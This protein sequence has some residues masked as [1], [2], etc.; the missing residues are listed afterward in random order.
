V[1][2]LAG[3]S[4]LIVLTRQGTCDINK[5]ALSVDSICVSNIESFSALVPDFQVLPHSEDR[6][7]LRHLTEVVTA[8]S[9]EF[10]FDE[11]VGGL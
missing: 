10:L 9:K 7:G 11:T 8:Q 3:L 2:F 5:S 1:R 4:S 6:L